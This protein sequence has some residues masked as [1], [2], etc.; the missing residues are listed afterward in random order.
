[1]TNNKKLRLGILGL[2]EGRSTM[3][4]ALTSTEIELIQICDLNEDLCR[5][6]GE[7][8]GFGNY[9]T[10]YEDMLDNPDIEAIAIYTPDHLHASHITAALRAGKHVVCTKPLLDDLKDAA[11]LLK[12]QEEK[13]LKLFV[14]QSS[15]F[16]EPMK[17]QR[18]DYEAGL[19][20]ELITVEAYYHADHRWFLAK[21]WS[22][23]PSF[24]WL[25][26]G[27]S[28]PVD[29][30]R[31][32][33]PDVEEVMGY[34]M[35]SA[36]GKKG[37]LKNP[38]TMHFVFRASDG[39][40]ARV[41]GAYTGPVQPVKRD[42]EMSCIL[43]GTEGCSQGDYMDIR[44]AITDNTGEERIVTWEH[45]LKY[46]FPFEGKSHHAGEYRNYLEYF[47]GCIRNNE[48]AYPDLREGI[49]TVALLK[50]ME[51]SLTSGKPEKVKDVLK[52]YGL[53]QSH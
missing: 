37:G 16:F 19:I 30:I 51:R 27:L 46:Y 9:T 13:G 14:G 15:R 32:Y 44:Y 20:G 49:G 18:K 28:H 1:M 40:V 29:F 50:A 24:Q 21:P 52:E 17:R 34:G 53:G 2:G 31:W 38:D 4:A 10:R 47:A 6:R 35:L 3:H 45:K 22:L 26:G 41:S 36:N 23:E 12:L 11:G 25:Y 33:L 5:K 8:M 48:T 42:S 39:R 43:R 7:E